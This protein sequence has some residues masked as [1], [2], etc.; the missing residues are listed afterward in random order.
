MRRMNAIWMVAAALMW[1]G[2]AMAMPAWQ[3]MEDSQCGDAEVCWDGDCLPTCT[4]DKD[5]GDG[6]Y[7]LIAST[8]DPV[9]P[10]PED[11]PDCDL[12]DKQPPG[13][14][15]GEAPE[16]VC[17][18]L[19]DTCTSDADC[20]EGEV[21]E[22]GPTISQGF[23]PDPDMPP[24]EEGDPM[25]EPPPAEGTCVPEDTWESECET[26]ADCPAG[27]MCA[28]AG[29]TSQLVAVDAPAC[30]CPEEEPDCGCDEEGEQAMPEPMPEPET[31]IYYACVPAPCESDADCGDDLACLSH[32]YQQCEDLPL[33]TMVP[34]RED[35]PDCGGSMEPRP[36]PECE[37]VTES[38]CGPKYLANCEADADCGEG[39]SCVAEEMCECETTSRRGQVDDAAG[40]DTGDGAE[41][42]EGTPEAQAEPIEPTGDGT[43]ACTCEPTGDMICELQELPCA[44]DDDCAIEGWT[45]M[46]APIAT[47]PCVWDEETGEEDCGDEDDSTEPSGQCLPETWGWGED[48]TM[49]SAETANDSGGGT[50]SSGG[51]GAPNPTDP[52]SGSGDGTDE[53]GGTSGGGGGGGCQTGSAP[54]SGLMGLALFAMAW[55]TRRK[56]ALER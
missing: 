24:G 48:G 37:T 25:P 23:Q 55:V 38:Y 53:D 1:C 2:Q 44:S 36:E 10:C 26:D 21:C 16:G 5:C 19:P 28:E 32:T 51:G 35:D 12:G 56:L 14:D 41:D 31:T 39:F 27:M 47:Q 18:A 45:C 8:N 22:M 46:L 9:M 52:G 20:A 40:I 54:A 6:S 42:D 29:A 34:C 49:G 3:C 17:I 13:T 50:T 11:E 7:C 33:T 15:P 30:V 43:E 4:A